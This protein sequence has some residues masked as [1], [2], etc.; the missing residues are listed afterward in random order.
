M[1]WAGFRP[2]ST[3]T[4]LICRLAQVSGRIKS[5]RLT[6]LE[7]DGSKNSIAECHLQ[8]TIHM[9]HPTIDPLLHCAACNTVNVCR[10]KFLYVRKYHT[11]VVI[12]K[13]SAQLDLASNFQTRERANSSLNQVNSKM[14]LEVLIKS[15]AKW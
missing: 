15:N 2:L 11:T 13:L 1:S 8:S 7:T 9:S 12:T 3:A 14:I 5:A 6:S 4:P 10:Y